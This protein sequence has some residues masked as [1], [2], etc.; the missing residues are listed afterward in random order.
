MARFSAL[1]LPL[2]DERVALPRMLEIP[3]ELPG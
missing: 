2:V 1:K 3:L